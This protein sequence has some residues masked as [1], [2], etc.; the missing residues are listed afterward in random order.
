M[1]K[2]RPL[3]FKD[4]EEL[5]NKVKEYFETSEN[6][7]FCLS[8]LAV[9]LDCD[10]K[11]LYNY[12]NKD[13]YFPTIKRAKTKIEAYIEQQGLIGGFN[14]TFSIFDLKNNH[15]WKDKQEIDTNIKVDKSEVDE[16]IDCMDKIK[17]DKRLN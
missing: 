14:S 6:E 7:P 17:E 10:R 4:K 1:K 13:D 2:G 9:A 12:S 15:G 8:G 3:L 5:D 11:T 16:L